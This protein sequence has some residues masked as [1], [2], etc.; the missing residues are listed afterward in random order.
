MAATI[1]R[2]IPDDVWFEV[3]EHIPHEEKQKLY[4][5]NRPLFDSAMKSLYRHV[6][7]DLGFLNVQ[8]FKKLIRLQCVSCD[9][10][11]IA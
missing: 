10:T 11:L 7:L 3:A 9:R 4:A 6:S 2:R 1:A 8:N 5:V